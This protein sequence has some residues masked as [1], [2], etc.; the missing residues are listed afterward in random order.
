MSENTQRLE[1][2][3]DNGTQNIN[4]KSRSAGAGIGGGMGL[5]GVLT[6]TKG[7]SR[8]TLANKASPP[9]KKP[10]KFGI[11]LLVLG[12]LG[13]LYLNGG[14]KLYSLL[15]I[16]TGGYIVYAASKFNSSVWP[17]LYKYW[18]DSWLCHKCGSI[19]HQP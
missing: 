4:T 1:V 13:L 18:H 9:A 19:Y 12:C 17:N 8:S 15:L 3:F 10:L 16:P 2:V 11:L 7:T 6:S 5:G 14:D